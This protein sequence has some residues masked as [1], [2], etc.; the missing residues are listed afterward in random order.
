VVSENNFE[1]A[2]TYGADYERI[3]GVTKQY[4]TVINTRYYLGGY[5]KDIT[6]G[7]TKY[8]Q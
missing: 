1:L 7:V 5:E 4:G 6:G 3:K 2:Y 8:I